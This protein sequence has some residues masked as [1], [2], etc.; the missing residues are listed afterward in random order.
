MMLARPLPAG[1][2]L[3]VCWTRSGVC[4][5]LRDDLGGWNQFLDGN[6]AWSYRPCSGGVASFSSVARTRSAF[7]LRVDF[8]SGPA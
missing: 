3:P 2:T 8:Q 4:R 5:R 1:M 6:E 7:S